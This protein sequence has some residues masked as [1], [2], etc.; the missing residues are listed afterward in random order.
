MNGVAGWSKSKQGCDLAQFAGEKK[1]ADPAGKLIC[2]FCHSLSQM[3][4]ER[5]VF[6]GPTSSC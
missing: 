4:Q 6:T 3:E 1:Q 5:R 2:E